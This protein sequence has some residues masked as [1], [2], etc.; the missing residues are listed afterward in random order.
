MAINFIF[1]SVLLVSLISLIGVF[2]LSISERKLKKSLF[3][4]VSF[5]VGV[6]LGDVFFHLLPETIESTGF[7]LQTSGSIL[8]AILV[9]FALEK[10]IQWHHHHHVGE[11]E[12]IHSFGYLNIFA[13]ALHNFLDGIIIAGSYLVSI[14]I[15]ITTTIAVVF[16]EIPQEIGDFGI[17]LK[18]G[19][20]K[21]EA[22][23]YNFLSALTAIIGA[24]LGILF[25]SQVT[26][27]S[28]FLIPFTAGSFLYIAG[29]DLIPELQKEEGA[30]FLQF[31]A[32]V[33]GMLVMLGLVFL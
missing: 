19:F 29:A 23:K 30:T 7:S 2:T 21:A 27:F 17:L 24:F 33:L 13:D 16:H 10:W 1:G 12:D 8:L 3:L 28:A 14:P 5:S 22:I 4:L 18:S 31:T 32:I 26:G 9:F 6:L 11:A 25:S 15:G 20:S